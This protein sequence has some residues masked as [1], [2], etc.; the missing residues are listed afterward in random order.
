M[1]EI[2][3]GSNN[4]NDRRKRNILTLTRNSSTKPAQEEI[5]IQLPSLLTSTDVINKPEEVLRET[6]ETLSSKSF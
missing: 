5:A 2:Q 1:G 3:L 4:I 6:V